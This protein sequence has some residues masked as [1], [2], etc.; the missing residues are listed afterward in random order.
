MKAGKWIGIG[1][2]VFVAGFGAVMAALNVDRLFFGSKESDGEVVVLGREGTPNVLVQGGAAA[3]LDFRAAAKKMLPSLVSIDTIAAGEDIFGRRVVRPAGS[4]SGVVVSEDGYIVTNNHVVTYQGQQASRVIVTLNDK[5]TMDGTIVGRDPRSDLAVIKI[6]RTGLTPVEFGDS[7]KLEIGEWVLAA[8]S[9]LGY[10]NTISAGI[11]SSK[12]RQLPSDNSAIFVDGIQTDAAINQG[13][14]G[15]PLCN[16]A[17]QLVGIN[18]A[19]ASFDGGSLGIGFSI[20]VNRMRSVV[21]DII[22]FG[23]VRYGDIR[24]VVERESKAI[25]SIDR[26]RNQL[27]N[28][29]NATSE[30]P[31]AGV[32]IRNIFRSSSAQDAGLRR[33][34]VVTA[35]DGKPVKEVMDYLVALSDKKPGQTLQMQIWSRGETKSVSVVLKEAAAMESEF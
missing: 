13:N 14:S 34:D 31:E 17:G 5:S 20:P 33:F 12:G 8:G 19:I 35:I 24:M 7:E 10:T 32:V 1:A 11:V 27:Q 9:P 26:Y 6:E 16:S 29:T 2:L 23:R 21:K 18:V 15:G 22:E 4:G 25:L 28:F 3:G 30:P